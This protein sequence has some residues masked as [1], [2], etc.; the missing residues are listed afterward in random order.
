[1][2]AEPGMQWQLPSVVMP[3]IWQTEIWNQSLHLPVAVAE[4]DEEVV[5]ALVEVDEVVGTTGGDE[6]VGLAEVGLAADDEPE[7]GVQTH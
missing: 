6:V 4:A 5:V 2:V 3:W 7:T 1:M